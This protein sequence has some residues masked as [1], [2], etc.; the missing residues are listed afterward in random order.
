MPTSAKGSR[1]L[2]AARIGAGVTLAAV[3]ALTAYGPAT[4][5]ERPE[6]ILP[7]GFGEPAAQPSPRATATPRPGTTA[8]ATTPGAA[9]TAATSGEMV[10]PLPSSTPTPLASATPTATPTIDPAVL[11]QYEMPASARRSLA[12]VGPAG[13]REGAFGADAFAGA[14]G[15]Y[16]EAL[17]R[18]VAAP[19]PSRWL[20]IVLRRAL[21]AQVDTPGHVN[22]ADFAA[23]RAWLLLRMGESVAA[24]ALVQSV[25]NAN[26][27]PKLYQVAMNAALATG[28]PAALC[29][30][31]DAGLATTRERGWT[32]AQ[33]MCA[34]LS[35]EPA[36]AKALVTAARRRNVATGIDLQLAQKV[37][38]AGPGGGQAVTIEW[39]GVGDLTAWR[40]GLA[41][42]TGV[43]I[44]DPLFATV[45]P[46]ARSWYAQS[47]GIPLADRLPSAEIAAGQGVLSAAALI[48]VYGA[49]DAASDMPGAAT[50][51]ANDLRTAYVGGDAE[52]RLSA[53]RS[54]WGNARNDADKAPSVGR[55][56]LTSR[57]A[58]RLPARLGVEDARFLVASMLTAGLD[59]SAAR[60]RNA[61]EE[62]GDAWAMIA[63]ADPDMGGR[64]SY[65]QLSSYT[66]RGDAALKQRLFFAGLAGLGR[67][68]PEDIER[69]AQALDVR[70][71][72]Q[73]SWTRAIERA[74]ADGQRGTVVV[75]AAIGMQTPNWRG[76]PPAML[77]R[78]VSALRAVGLEGEAR[79][80]AAEA[81]ARV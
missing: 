19:L 39:A 58:A 35:A 79:M 33:A 61:V 34:G 50:A 63:L 36:R 49:V 73:N 57:A 42:A 46:Q 70:I 8:A 54:L 41:T 28:D 65:R 60:W 47:P 2:L 18:R 6:S 1:R 17:M 76:V 4:G 10:Q 59:R 52:A 40:F 77:Y 78:I 75:L 15:P 27:T 21:V 30:I 44:P 81:L 3:A 66:G 9:P 23:E 43:P 55:L 74:A 26:Y 24:R 13:P 67:L 48:D 12:S 69:A 25:D 56:V 80:I 29:P 20:S 22:G 11:A 53:M 32:L 31:A 7:P 38:G 64:M 62:G 51:T 16:V 72:M 14:D 37:V 5:Q 45:G 71:G 68:S